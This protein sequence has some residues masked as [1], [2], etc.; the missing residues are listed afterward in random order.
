MQLRAWRKWYAKRN[1]P[2]PLTAARADEFHPDC[3]QMFADATSSAC[4]P[5]VRRRARSCTGMSRLE[6][7]GQTAVW[8]KPQRLSDQGD[9]G[10]RNSRSYLAGP[11]GTTDTNETKHHRGEMDRGRGTGERGREMGDRQ[12]G[13]GRGGELCESFREKKQRARRGRG[14]GEMERGDRGRG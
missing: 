3:V 2:A 13:S 7:Y 9:C 10:D 4:G 11:E 6:W 14:G 1:G 5:G 8:S 12:N